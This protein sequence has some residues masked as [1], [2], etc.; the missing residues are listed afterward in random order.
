MN[1]NIENGQKVALLGDNGCGKTTLIKI[2]LG[3]EGFKGSVWKSKV[4]KVAYLPQ[5]MWK[6]EEDETILSLAQKFDGEYKTLFLTNLVGFG[7]KREMFTHRLSKMSSGERMKIKLNELIL[8]DFNLLILDEPTNH[9]D[10]ENRI[11]LEKVLKGFKGSLIV[12]SHDEAFI[13]NVC[14]KKLAI[15]NKTIVEVE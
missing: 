13:D 14:N 5:N 15:K 4:L 12:V 1:F 6:F 3:E 8:S 2:L 11:F 9:L 10:L 7:F